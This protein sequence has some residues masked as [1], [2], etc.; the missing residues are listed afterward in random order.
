MG[1]TGGLEILEKWIL[2]PFQARIEIQILRSRVHSPATR[3]S[4]PPTVKTAV[5]M[6]YSQ[7]ILSRLLV[8]VDK[9]VSDYVYPLTVFTDINNYVEL[10]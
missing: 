3:S 5:N 10:S 4:D 2:S 9:H 6:T 1:L 8:G 7:F